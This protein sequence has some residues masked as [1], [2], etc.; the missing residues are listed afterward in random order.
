M[1]LFLIIAAAIIGLNAITFGTM[2]IFYWI[3][4]RHDR[5][6]SGESGRADHDGKE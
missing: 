3:E 5:D 2:A 4:R 1:E 6:H